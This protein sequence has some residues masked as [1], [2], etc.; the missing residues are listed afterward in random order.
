ME[1][2]RPSRSFAM[3]SN[4]PRRALRTDSG[5]MAPAMWLAVVAARA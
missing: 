4:A 2:Q 5:A 1:L 3:S